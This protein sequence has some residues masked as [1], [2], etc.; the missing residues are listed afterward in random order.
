MK[1]KI[2]KI[3]LIIFISFF[4]NA[5]TQEHYIDRNKKDKDIKQVKLV[6]AKNSFH[7]I[8]PEDARATA[9]ILANHIKKTNN[10]NNDYTVELVNSEKDI[11]ENHNDFDLLLLTTEQYLKLR[12]KMPIEPFCTNYAN[13]HYGF[14]YHLIV[15]LKDNIKN[16]KQLQNES[17]YIQAH[18]KD[19][20][21]S[22]WL[23]KLLKEINVKNR[24]EFFNRIA[25]DNKA[26]NVLLP[27]IFNKAKACII[28]DAS[29]EL[30][31]EL[32]PAIK[33]QIR[34]LYTSEP[35]ILGLTCL[36]SNKKNEQ[37]YKLLK[38]TLLKLQ[39]SQYG[40]QFLDLFRAEK[41]VLFKEE[42]LN[43]YFNLT[44]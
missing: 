13:G 3:I 38:E 18:T 27:V 14:V 10:D 9:Q 16:L 7:N 2:E 1:N 35:I 21:A 11:L 12:N 4:V 42:Y 23:N 5:Q 31:L 43:E 44:K 41:L 30:L 26:T 29:L 15:N 37:S 34:I 36:N 8:K 33:S 32:N 17:I 39:E 28:T 19:Q 22:L 6:F 25:I 20:S 40:R 24:D